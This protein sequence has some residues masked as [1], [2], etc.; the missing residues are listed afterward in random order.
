M[1]NN[2]T[3]TCSTAAKFASAFELGEEVFRKRNKEYAAKLD[4]KVLSAYNYSRLKE[5]VTQT[6]SVRSPYIYSEE[7][8]TDDMELSLAYVLKRDMLTDHKKVI[9]ETLMSYASAEP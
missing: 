1:V 9:A 4:Q 8:W 2:T 7:N 5:G 3:G 6:A